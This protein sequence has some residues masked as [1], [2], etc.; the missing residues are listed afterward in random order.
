MSE[1]ET[2]FLAN[3]APLREDVSRL[4]R[5]VGEMLAEQ[6][7]AEFLAVVE[8]LRTTAISLRASHSDPAEL[9]R[10]LAGLDPLTADQLTRLTAAA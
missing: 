2:E 5:I 10:A 4:G 3:D 8:R 6:H 9:S 1:R 7:G